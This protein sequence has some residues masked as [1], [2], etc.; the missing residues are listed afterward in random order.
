VAAQ[1]PTLPPPAVVVFDVNET[2]VDISGLRERFDD[3]RLLERWF[4]ATLRD[5]IALAAAGGY[6]DFATVATANLLPFMPLDSARETMS[7]FGE[8]DLHPDVADGMGRLAAAGVR[9][10]TLTNGSAETCAELLRRGGV[11]DLV[12]RNLSVAEVRRWKPTAD[13]YRLAVRHAA[14]PADRVALVAVHPWDVDGARRAGLVGAW[15]NRDGR[16]YPDMFTPPDV[17]A[18]D[19]GALADTL[20]RRD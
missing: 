14:V 15:L 4:A 3:G 12:E 7:A 6:A 1:A 11:A 9:L 2:L 18:R 10:M 8:L 17:T 16:P 20:L 5:G 19:L 13:P